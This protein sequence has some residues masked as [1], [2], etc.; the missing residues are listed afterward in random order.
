MRITNGMMSKN[1]L[2]NLQLNMKRM[3][4]LN[5]QAASGKLF[6][7]PSDA[8]VAM[9][10]SLK[11]YTDVSRVNQYERN[12]RDAQSWLHSTEDAL[13]EVGEILHRARELAVD[14]ANG[15]KTESDTQ[16]AAEEI[17]Q[18]K[19]QLIKLA[20]TTHA[21]RSIFTGFQ[22]DKK[23]LND[24]GTYD[25][26]LGKDASGALINE[27]SVYNVGVA[28]SMEI[29]MLGSRLFGVVDDTAPN[30]KDVLPTGEATKL[31]VA[32]NEKS[33]FINVFDHLISAM[34]LD[35]GD[36]SVGGN[37][38]ENKFD[39]TKIS[40]LI[41]NIDELKENALTLRAEVGAKTNRLE[42]TSK[43]L[44]SEELNFT[45]VL[46]ENED[47]DEAEI[48]M[49]FKMAEAVY[50][51]SLAMGGKTIQPTLVDFLR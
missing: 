22:T 6:D 49:K 10:K 34:G 24:D 41:G 18:L 47:V 11:L 38:I 30:T 50:N 51:A 46:S 27:V 8:P 12:L 45:T 3:S 17:K 16:K 29:N 7:R 4:R 15:T 21:G 20:N 26:N 37:G 39:Q 36:G 25:I 13:H 42:M 28:E 35:G 40:S 19:D 9:A 43:R 14:M 48:I 2:N 1:L 32:K 5:E 44:S 33:H 23:L 31:D